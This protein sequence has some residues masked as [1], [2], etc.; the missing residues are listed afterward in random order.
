VRHYSPSQLKTW[1]KCPR[2]WAWR[3]VRGV[4]TPPGAALVVGKAVHV[5]AET[6]H[7]R[8]MDLGTE[9]SPDAAA[10][11][12]PVEEAADVAADAFERGAGDVPWETEDEKRDAA[13]DRAVRMGSRYVSHVAPTTGRPIAVERKSELHPAGRDWT[14]VGYLDAVTE[15]AGGKVVL[16]DTKSSGKAPSGASG[17]NIV[18]PNDYRRQLA[19]YRWMW[20]EGTGDNPDATVID[21]VWAGKRDTN[22]A[23]APADVNDDDETLLF[24]LL[25]GMHLMVKA[26]L[27][28][29]NPDSWAC[30]AKWCGYWDRCIKRL[31]DV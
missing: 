8:G 12:M 21:Y 3:Y 27:F 22:S 6:Y 14:L 26:G 19:A 2:A 5:P 17:G 9:W 15:E 10:A 20:R 1:L 4:I 25:D 30:N 23:T 24:S 11:A 29:R 16:R 18:V 7:K 28:P 31:E 13:K